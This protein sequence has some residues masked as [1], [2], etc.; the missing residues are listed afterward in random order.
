M[1]LYLQMWTIFMVDRIQ[2]FPVLNR[3]LFIEAS[4]SQMAWEE[5]ANSM[6]SR[7]ATVTNFKLP[8]G[9]LDVRLGQAVHTTAVI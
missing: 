7:I 6:V 9:E 3:A 4:A 8:V 2:E 1:Q 5:L